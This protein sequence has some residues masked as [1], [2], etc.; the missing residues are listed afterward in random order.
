MD[1]SKTDLY[2]ALYN[3][4]MTGAAD[5]G[6]MVAYNYFAGEPITGLDEGRPLFARNPGGMLLANFIRAHLYSSVATLKLGLDILFQKEHVALDSLLGH[7]G[8]FKTPVVG[9][10]IM[11]AAAGVPVTV[12][13]TAG[14]GGPYGMALLAAYMRCKA[15]SETLEDFLKNR[16][17]FDAPSTT[18]A[19]TPEDLAGF[20]AYIARYSAGLAME[21]AAVDTLK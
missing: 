3:H 21:R 13:E 7:G 2:A 11:A 6:G 20:S 14:E 10:R 1:I 9:Q 5:C 8:L 18:I 4:A 15:D 19:P 16:V 12:M 17:F